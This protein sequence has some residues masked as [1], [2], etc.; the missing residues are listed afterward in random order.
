MTYAVVFASQTGNTRRVAE[1]IRDALPAD[2]CLSFGP[3]SPAA[4]GAE[5]LFVGSWADKGDCAPEVAA[6]LEGLSDQRVA[7]FGTCLLYTSRC[8]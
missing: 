2:S 7:L 1:A 6:F 8:V 3:P 5:L 4:A